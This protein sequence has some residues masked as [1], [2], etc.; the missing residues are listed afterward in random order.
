MADMNVTGNL[1]LGLDRVDMSESSPETAKPNTEAQALGAS[2]GAGATLNI[3]SSRSPFTF[4]ISGDVNGIV[5]QTSE[6]QSWSPLSAEQLTLLGIDPSSPQASTYQ[7]DQ[8]RFNGIDGVISSTIG[9]TGNS[10]YFGVGGYL[11]GRMMG[12]KANAPLEGSLQSGGA[13]QAYGTSIISE[14]QNLGFVAKGGV[15][16]TDNTMLGARFL[17]N[18][19]DSNVDATNMSARNS[20]EDSFTA[21]RWNLS[22]MVSRQFGNGFQRSPRPDTD[23]DG[24]GS[25]TDVPNNSEGMTQQEATNYVQSELDDIMERYDCSD[26]IIRPVIHKADQ[27]QGRQFGQVLDSQWNYHFMM[28]KTV[29]NSTVETTLTNTG[30]LTTEY[31]TLE[32]LTAFLDNCEACAAE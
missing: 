15:N 7:L 29:Q 2:I 18:L 14:F 10:G 6:Y 17:M 5:G 3:K 16:I 4:G 30:D 11:S 31:H 20:N 28:V 25:I 13:D 19:K 1:L 27:Y 9:A 32:S 8:T 12:P 24:I 22:L 23:A 26:F 21:E